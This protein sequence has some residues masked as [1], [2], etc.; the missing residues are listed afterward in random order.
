MTGMNMQGQE[1]MTKGSLE[2]RSSKFMK[3]TPSREQDSYKMLFL[4][5]KQWIL[6]HLGS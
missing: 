6:S 4:H 2:D 1:S 3:L 5:S